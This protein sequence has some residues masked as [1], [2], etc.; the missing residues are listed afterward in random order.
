[1]HTYIVGM[2]SSFPPYEY[3]QAQMEKAYIRN[4]VDP[5]TTFIDRVFKATQIDTCRSFLSEDQLFK[6][7]SREEYIRY[8]RDGLLSMGI[9]A[10][11]RAIREW[12]GSTSAITHIVYGTMTGAIYAPTMDVQLIN[13]LSL[14]P[15]TKRINIE[16]MG[17]LTGYR[18]IALASSLCKEDPSNRVL[19]VVGDI[20]SALGNQFVPTY[21]RSNTIVASLF[22]DSCG[23]CIVS[24]DSDSSIY[25]IMNHESMIIP[26]T[27]DLVSYTDKDGGYIQLDISREL[28]DA[29]GVHIPSIVSSLLD[30]YDVCIDDCDISCHT[31]GPKVLN[32]VR[33]S[34]GV[35]DDHMR[36]SWYVMKR[37]G[38][39]SGSSNIV[40]LDHNRRLS[41]RRDVVCISMGPGVGVETL[42]LRR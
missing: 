10:A 4:V 1:M 29:I 17:C 23:A 16:G 26:D 24:N 36:A 9:D 37:Y 41:N 21:S 13:H 15:S 7:M 40:V 42:Y 19:V 11:A 3:T 2:G 38:N 32:I 31:G 22:R 5:D 39:L 18:C 33:D 28:P 34:L 35:T 14:S 8:T 27:I 30:G 20:R 6:R 25:T 12:G